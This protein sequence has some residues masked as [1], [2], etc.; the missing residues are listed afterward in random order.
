ME[1]G[2][3]SDYQKP[4]AH[5]HFLGFLNSGADEKINE[6]STGN[7]RCLAKP[8]NKRE[9]L[10]NMDTIVQQTNGKTSATISRLANWKLI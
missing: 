10:S 6:S 4:P 2:W 3:Q 5:I 8:I 7:D 1:R 9:L